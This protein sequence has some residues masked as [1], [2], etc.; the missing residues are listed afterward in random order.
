MNINCMSCF[1]VQPDTLCTS[2]S[3]TRNNSG[4]YWIRCVVICF[5]I[6]N[7]QEVFR[8]FSVILVIANREQQ[9]IE[10]VEKLWKTIHQLTVR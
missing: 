10:K 5:L 1:R 2:A 6:Q 7:F 4:S 3:V 9:L 8:C